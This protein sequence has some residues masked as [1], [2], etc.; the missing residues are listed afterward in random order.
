MFRVGSAVRTGESPRSAQRTLHGQEPSRRGQVIT[1][2]YQP[3]P[4]TEVTNL[5]S[6]VGTDGR[7]VPPPGCAALGQRYGENELRPACLLRFGHSLLQ[8]VGFPRFEI[9]P[10][11]RLAG[12]FPGPADRDFFEGVGRTEPDRDGELAL[13]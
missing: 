2:R 5:D 10:F 11:L 1:P 13:A 4:K 8:P 9:R 12:V 3:D 6:R 7:S